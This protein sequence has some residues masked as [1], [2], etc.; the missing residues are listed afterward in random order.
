L[1]QRAKGDV[2]KLRIAQR[3]QTDTA[4]TLKWIAK[5]L[6]MGTWMHVANR[7]QKAKGKREPAN[8]P[9]FGLV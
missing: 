6:H 7:L 1:A 9:E 3:L 2:R 5:E 8:Q 4:V